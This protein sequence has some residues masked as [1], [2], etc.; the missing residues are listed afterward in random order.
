MLL[1]AGLA[2]VAVK[3]AVDDFALPQATSEL[4]LWGI[5]DYR[6]RPTEGRRRLLLAAQRH[7][8]VRLSANAITVG[9]SATSRSSAA[10]RT[11]S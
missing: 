1:P 8:I 5:G 10:A 7:D 2:L 3:F 9:R 4:R 6:H 11:A